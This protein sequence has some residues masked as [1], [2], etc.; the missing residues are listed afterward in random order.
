MVFIIGLN[1]GIFPSANLSEGFLNDSD[2]EQLKQIGLELAK[3]TLENIYEDEFNIYKA[4]TTAEEKLFLSYAS[5]NSEG[6]TLRAS[7]LI[8][9]IKKTVAYSFDL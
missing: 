5:S 7:I 8:T 3:G 1:D 4:F 6:S 9:K 2:R